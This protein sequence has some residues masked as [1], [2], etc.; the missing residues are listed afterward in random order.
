MKPNHLVNKKA[1]QKP[2]KNTAFPKIWYETKLKEQE[3]LESL[4]ILAVQRIN[5]TL[6]ILE[7][8]YCWDEVYLF[9]SVAEKG[10]FRRNSDIDIAVKGLDKFDYYEFVGEISSLMDQRVDVILLE[11]CHFSNAIRKKGIKWKHKSKS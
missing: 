6:N 11:K 7:K 10:K 4:R 3:D 1:F 9:G 8:K 5:K 2:Q